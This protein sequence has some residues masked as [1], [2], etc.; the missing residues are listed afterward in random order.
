[1]SEDQSRLFSSFYRARNVGQ[2]PG[3]GLGLAGA[4][5]IVE[6]HGGSL[7]VESREGSGSTFVV[8]LPL[9]ADVKA[10]SAAD[11]QRPVAEGASLQEVSEDV[12]P[13]PSGLC[14]RAQYE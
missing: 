5:Q 7:G 13:E 6:R 2:I 9:G 3:T 4:R 11:V 1:L 12:Q 8:R 14:G 10:G